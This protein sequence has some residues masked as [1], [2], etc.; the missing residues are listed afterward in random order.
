MNNVNYKK[1]LSSIFII[2]AIILIF[3]LSIQLN[4][5]YITLK[6]TANQY[7]KTLIETMN[8]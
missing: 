7:N 2:I 6:N 5:K 3:Y 4:N 1:F 8:Q